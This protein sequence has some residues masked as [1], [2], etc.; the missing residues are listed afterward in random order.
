MG[1]IQLLHNK[2]SYWQK[3]PFYLKDENYF[4]TFRIVEAKVVY[5]PF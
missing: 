1:P 5:S 2:V 3:E 4:L